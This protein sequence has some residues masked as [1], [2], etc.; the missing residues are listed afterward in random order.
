MSLGDCL[1]ARYGD[2]V[3]LR[4]WSP[5]SASAVWH[6]VGTRLLAEMLRS[7]L[8][9]NAAEAQLSSAPH[10]QQLVYPRFLQPLW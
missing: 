4:V 9:D 10:T 5:D 3:Y 2:A 8:H 1:Q 7:S 6:L